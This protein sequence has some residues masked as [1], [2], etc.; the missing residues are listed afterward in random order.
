MQLPPVLSCNAASDSTSEIVACGKMPTVPVDIKIGDD[1]SRPQK[2]FTVT[3]R[4]NG[5]MQSSELLSSLR[6]TDPR[7]E[8]AMELIAVRSLNLLMGRHPSQDPAV[9]TTGRGTTRWF[10]T[11]GRMTAADLRG[12]L[13]VVRGYFSSM[14]TNQWSTLVARD[15][16]FTCR[17]RCVSSTNIVPGQPYHVDYVTV[18]R[19]NMIQFSCQRPPQNY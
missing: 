17:P 2:V 16:R 10:W 9:V 8:Y 15:D 5:V 18:Q 6:Q 19:Q 7:M 14:P 11:D 3:L 4:E 13:Q 1:P 12:G